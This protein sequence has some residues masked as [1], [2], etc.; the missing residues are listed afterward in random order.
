MPATMAS[1][2]TGRGPRSRSRIPATGWPT[3]RG[4]VAPGSGPRARP[5][6]PGCCSRGVYHDCAGLRGEC[7]ARGEAP[8]AAGDCA[9]L[10]GPVRVRAQLP[11]LCERSGNA[12]EWCPLRGAQSAQSTRP[13]QSSGPVTDLRHH[14]RAVAESLPVGTVV[15]ITRENLLELLSDGPRDTVAASASGPDTTAEQLLTVQEVAGRFGISE[16]W[17]IAIGGRSAA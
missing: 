14:Y 12:S 11:P 16:D 4:R 17:S 3:L 10:R 5:G 9:A 15:P 8:L 13:A 6:G 2:G 1:R 7:A